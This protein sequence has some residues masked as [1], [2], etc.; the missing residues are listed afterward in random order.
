MSYYVRISEVDDGTKIRLKE[1]GE[2][3]IVGKYDQGKVVENNL[4]QKQ[5][6]HNKTYVQIVAPPEAK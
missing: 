6:L 5:R 4:K 1:G 2:Y 3:V